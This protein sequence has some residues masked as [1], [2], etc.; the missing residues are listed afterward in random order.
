VYGIRFDKVVAYVM[1]YQMATS[2]LLTHLCKKSKGLAFGLA[3]CADISA[4]KSI[5]QSRQQTTYGYIKQGNGWHG[6]YD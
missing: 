5:L 2:W 4:M 6:F 3:Y 1:V